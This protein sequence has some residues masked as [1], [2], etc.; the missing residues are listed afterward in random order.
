MTYEWVCDNHPSYISWVK[1]NQPNMLLEKV[2]T[3]IDVKETKQE[4]G[5]LTPNMNF[6]NEGPELYSSSYL[7]KMKEL[8]KK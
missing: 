2:T 4:F 1:E 7:N 8:N 5:K 6:E 3:V